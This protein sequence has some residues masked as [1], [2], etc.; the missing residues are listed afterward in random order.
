MPDPKSLDD[1]DFEPGEFGCK[2]CDQR[3][4]ECPV[5]GGSG[6]GYISDDDAV[7]CSTC[8]GEGVVPMTDEEYAHEMQLLVEKPWEQ[9]GS[10]REERQ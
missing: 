3:G 1:D 6:L 7:M 9:P 8:D 2:H 4:N 10:S 5:C